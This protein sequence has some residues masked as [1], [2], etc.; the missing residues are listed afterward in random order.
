LVLAVGTAA[1]ARASAV[2]PSLQE[3]DVL[4]FCN[5]PERLDRPGAYADAKLSGGRTYRVFFHYRN[6]SSRTQPLVV[7]FQGSVGKPLTLLVHK[8]IAEPQRDPPLA[9][10]RAI[11]RYLNAPS[12]RLVGRGGVRFALPLRPR[13]VASGI[14]TVRANQ[15]CRLRI[16]FRDNRRV[17]PGARVV[18]VATPRRDVTVRLTAK[19]GP[20]YYRIGVPDR[21][22]VG[23]LDGTY[24][25]VY[26][27]RVEA[28]AGSRV[29]VT[30]SPRGGKAGLVGSVNGALRSSDILGPEA[31]AVFADV[32]IGKAGLVVMTVPFGGVFYPVEVAFHLLSP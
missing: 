16:Y 6:A 31:L 28:P 4:L 21:A 12:Q 15:D 20:Q 7:A 24:G 8:G 23:H 5:R 18:T 32:V 29:R 19:S 14:L 3:A 9:G 26:A 22:L 25:L 11:E 17:V 2:P 13:D 10:K 30:F 1:P 27:F